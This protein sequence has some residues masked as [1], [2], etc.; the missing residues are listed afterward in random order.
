MTWDAMWKKASA[1]ARISTYLD[2]AQPKG[3]GELL[4]LAEADKAAGLRH[5]ENAS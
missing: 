2:L 4:S 3:K 1:R 5:S